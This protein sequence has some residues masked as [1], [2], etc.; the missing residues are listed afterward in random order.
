M[1]DKEREEEKTIEWFKA[2]TKETTDLRR[3]IFHLFHN[4]YTGDDE[5]F[6]DYVMRIF[7]AIME[8]NKNLK[9]E[10]EK[11]KKLEEELVKLKKLKEELDKLKEIEKHKN[12]AE[13]NSPKYFLKSW[14]Y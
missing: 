6:P 2:Q 9:S 4:K 14:G 11:I 3:M 13:I 8:E 12:S 1:E 7:R 5:Y 10:V